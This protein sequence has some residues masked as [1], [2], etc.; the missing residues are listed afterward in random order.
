MIAV[1][2][3]AIGA[4]GVHL[5]ATG[6]AGGQRSL[7]RSHDRVTDTGRN[8]GLRRRTDHWL[9]QAGLS[10]LRWRDVG[11]VCIAMFAIAALLSFAVFGGVAS[12]VFAGVAFATVPPLVYRQR[13]AARLAAAQEAWPRMIEE[14]RVLTGHAGTSIPQALFQVGRRAPLELRDAFDSA[15]REW[16][17]TTDFARALTVLQAKLADP[18]A[19]AACET[20]LTAH[21]IGGV[22]LDRRLVDLADDRL[23]DV[24]GRKDARA[25][26]AGARFARGFVLIVP[27][28]MALVGL[29]IGEGRTAY[30]SAGGQAAVLLGF[31]VMTICWWWAG[32]IMTI[33]SEQRVFAR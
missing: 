29:T 17:L 5:L 8:G 32:R 33:P 15:H 16:L 6:A 9:S 24:Q 10:E 12:S 1:L 4:L 25:K 31:L 22:E 19:D 13:R 26:Q 18:T 11:A 20:L 21:E 27:L 2:I 30:Q 28:G 23:A 14:I 7:R 3:A